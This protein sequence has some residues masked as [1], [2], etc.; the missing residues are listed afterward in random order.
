MGAFLHKIFAPTVF[1]IG[2]V[3]LL[4][5]LLVPNFE[6]YPPIGVYI[7]VLAF[8]AAIM[9]MSPMPE[10]WYTKAVW[11]GILGITLVLE[12]QTLYH[13]RDKYDK[14]QAKNTTEIISKAQEGFDKIL[15]GQRNS[16]KDMLAEINAGKKE[17]RQQFSSLLKR[18]EHLFNQQKDLSKELLSVARETRAKVK[19]REGALFRL[20]FLAPLLLVLF[21]KVS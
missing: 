13:E 18:E 19:E 6:F 8:L 14:Q 10:K 3:W 11:I 15:T 17:E 4:L 9:S 1:F 5:V 20:I 16:F 7:G 2:L 21:L 12:I